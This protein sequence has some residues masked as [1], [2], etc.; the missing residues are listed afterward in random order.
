MAQPLGMAKAVVASARV[1]VSQRG[2]CSREVLL[3]GLRIPRACLL[4]WGWA[5]ITRTPVL[6]SAGAAR[7][8]HSNPCSIP[9]L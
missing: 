7:T 5:A 6:S 9:P 8:T 1:L 2:P 3:E 4:G